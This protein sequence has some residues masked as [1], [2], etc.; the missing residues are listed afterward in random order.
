MTGPF[1][2]LRAWKGVPDAIEQAI[3]MAKSD[4]PDSGSPNTRE[5]E[6]ASM[7][8]LMIHCGGVHLRSLRGMSP[9]FGLWKAIFSSVSGME[10]IL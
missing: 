5:R 3:S 10:I 2:V 7:R 9:N 6:S 1:L 4:L 8:V